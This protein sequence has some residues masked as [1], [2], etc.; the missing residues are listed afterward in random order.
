MIDIFAG[1]GGLSEGFSSFVPKNRKRHPFRVKLS[2]EAN[3]HALRTLRLRSFFR[4]F[5]H[6]RVPDSYYQYIRGEI[7]LVELEKRHS[8]EYKHAEKEVWLAR[9]G[10]EGRDTVHRRIT[11]ALEGATDWI[12]LGG[13][14]CQA[15]SMVGRSRMKSVKG[16]EF[17][18]D[19]RHFLYKEYLRILADH[20]PTVFV[21]ENVKG[22]LSSTVDGRLIFG[23]I[24]S[25]LENPSRVKHVDGEPAKGPQYTLHSLNGDSSTSGEPINPAAFVVRSEQHGIPQRR[26]RLIIVGVLHDPSKDRYEPAPIVLPVQSEVGIEDV[27]E[28]LPRLRSGVSKPVAGMEAWIETLTTYAQTGTL[29]HQ[30]DLRSKI[31]SIVTDLATESETAPLHQGEHFTLYEKNPRHRP[32]WYVSDRLGGVTNHS[33]RN[34]MKTD[35]SRYLYSAAYADLNDRSA[36]LKD[37]PDSLLPAH[38]NARRAQ[39]SGHFAD[40]FRVQRKG[41]AA[42]TITSHISKDGHY[43]IH[44]DGTQCRSLTVREAARI[45]TF[46]DDYHFE[47][48]RTQQYVQVGN[49]V[50]PLLAVQI[51]DVVYDLVRKRSVVKKG[52]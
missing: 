17:D 44:Y 22:L 6:S 42:T 34:H 27:I 1:P 52:Q 37:L 29:D 13:P 23:E 31:S 10:K 26:H 4:Q 2:I 20:A 15:Y 24:L 40:R 50:P 5:R 32:D 19:H 14:P 25:D 16:E 47:G 30:D 48:N 51:A 21:F 46:P 11:N 45:Q 43:Y 39:K 3:E 18:K 9:L 12:L 36:T 33:A 49:A 41:R 8:R 38:K 35:L 7:G 28:D